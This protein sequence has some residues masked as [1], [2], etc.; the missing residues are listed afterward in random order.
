[1]QISWVAHR[2]NLECLKTSGLS[3]ELTLEW[4]FFTSLCLAAEVMS[5]G[6]ISCMRMCVVFVVVAFKISLKDKSC[7]EL[8]F[9]E[10][11]NMLRAGNWPLGTG[12]RWDTFSGCLEGLKHLKVWLSRT[13]VIL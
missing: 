3:W 6:D 11:Q 8:L 1:M 7:Y 13:G 10:K 9:Q 5:V 2:H 12:E 4:S